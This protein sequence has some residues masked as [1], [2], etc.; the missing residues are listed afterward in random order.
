MPFVPG[1]ATFVA[2]VVITDDGLLPD[3]DRALPDGDGTLPDGD[4]PGKTCPGLAP[5]LLAEFP[6][7]ALPPP[8]PPPFANAGDKPRAAAIAI[9]PNKR[10]V[11]ICKLLTF[12]LPLLWQ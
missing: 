12:T 1:D 11:F 10:D 3:D 9:V 7:P 8:A 6:A 5:A 2:G 4:G